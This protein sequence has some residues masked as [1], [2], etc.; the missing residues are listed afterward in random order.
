M[1][2]ALIRLFPSSPPAQKR[3]KTKRRSERARQVEQQKAGASCL[4][5]G[6]S[7]GVVS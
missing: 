1:R 2:A 6:L 3:G 7:R 5:I 4:M